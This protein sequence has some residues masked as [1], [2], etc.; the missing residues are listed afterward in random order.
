MR[1]R[2][3]R[4]VRDAIRGNGATGMTRT[5]ARTAWWCN[6]LWCGALAVL[7]AGCALPKRPTG[8][9]PS[10][11]PTSVEGLAAAIQSD[12][13]RSDKAPDGGARAQLADEA[14]AYA[15]ACLAKASQA[16]GCLYGSGLAY[17]LE[18]RAHPGSATES[19]RAMLDALTKA[20]A[21]DPNYDQAGPARVRAQVLLAAPGWPLGPGDPDAG[22]DSARRA[23]QLRPQY[24]PNLLVLGEALAK[25]GDAKGAH[26]AYTQARDAAQALPSADG[27][28]DGW[29]READQG[30]QR[31]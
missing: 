28:R 17:G 4:E 21:A 9:L 14:S 2:A 10:S 22:L 11:A 26:A 12:A 24:P 25:T 31:K 5:T 8:P 1:A 27:D 7:V 13:A 16:A 15:Q 30:L 18:A 6:V 29:I 19:L 20:D 3:P 23:V